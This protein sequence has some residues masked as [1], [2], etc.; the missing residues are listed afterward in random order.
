M[1]RP[2][3]FTT[4]KETRYPL[5]K[6][7]DGPQGRSGRV[8]KISPHWDSFLFF[9]VRVFFSFIRCSFLPLCTFTS[10]ILMSL[11]RLQH[12]TQTPMPP[13]GYFFA[14]C[15]L[16]VLLCPDCPGF[17][18]CLLLYKT[19]IHGPGGVRTRNLSK[20]AAS[21]PRRG[22]LGHWLP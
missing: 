8:R 17:V 16:A 11:I 19:N 18:F 5:Y 2:G 20:R 14:L 21:D 9:L 13:A 1:P 3:R 10:S 6:R 4:G 15:T 7:L 22:P 12:T